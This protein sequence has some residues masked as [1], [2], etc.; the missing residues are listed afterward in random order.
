MVRLF[1]PDE[2]DPT[3]LDQVVEMSNE[4]ESAISAKKAS[5]P[6]QAHA[7]SNSRDDQIGITLLVLT[8]IVLISRISCSVQLGMAKYYF[9]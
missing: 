6:L 5:K 4:T 7:I 2:R 3:G 9:F 1:R 8:A